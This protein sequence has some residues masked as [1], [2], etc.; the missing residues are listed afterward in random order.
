[1]QSIPRVNVLGVGV[2]AVDMERAVETI[3]A[4]AENGGRGYVSFVTVHGVM[5]AQKNPELK[6]IYNQTL[7]CNPDGMP[8]SWLGWMQGF[9]QMDRVYGPDFT[10]ELFRRT[11]NRPFRH[12][13]FGGKPGVAE[14]LRATL[15]SRFPG[16]AIC[17][18]YTPP[19]RP[20]DDGEWR[21]L[22]ARF[23][24]LQPHFVWVG[25]STPK[26][27]RFMAEAVQR[28]LGCNVLLG[29]GA[30][31]DFHTGNVRQAPRWVMRAGLEWF[32]RLTQEPRRLWYRYVILN[33]L[34]VWR[35]FLQ[36]TGLRKYRV[37]G[38]E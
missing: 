35:I 20:L 23:E 30:A 22:A 12:F 24:E 19:F 8:L 21:E 15:E 34:F 36:L 17:G 7:L 33:P 18:T 31:F 26:Q 16:V 38:D 14:Q 32:F 1:M 5:E 10:L 28:G 2:S 13:L 27:E 29:V 9:S 37:T 11:Q 6:R 3:L 4:A 25:I